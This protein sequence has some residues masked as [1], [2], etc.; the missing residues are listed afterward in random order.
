MGWDTPLEEVLVR[1]NDKSQWPIIGIYKDTHMSHLQHETSTQAIRF[2]QA[3]LSQLVL[4]VRAENLD[5]TLAF[6]ETVWNDFIPNRPF[7]YEFVDDQIDRLYHADT[8]FGQIFGLFATLAIFLG[9]LGL[10]GLTSYTTTQRTKEIGIRK[11]LG[12]S[13]NQVTLLLTKTFLHLVLIANALAWPLAYIFMNNWLQ[14][15]A[16]RTHLKFSTFLLGGLLA[17]LIATITVSYQAIKTARTNPTDALRY[18]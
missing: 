1:V 16:H 7:E 12:A 18:E 17:L 4:K 14:N 2:N 15:Y 13:T 10:F 11:V 5:E 3:L 6:I 9:C 8:R